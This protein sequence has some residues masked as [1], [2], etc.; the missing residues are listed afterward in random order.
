MGKKVVRILF[1]DGSIYMGDA[2]AIEVYQDSQHEHRVI[3]S[4]PSH[5]Q[6]FPLNDGKSPKVRRIFVGRI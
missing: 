2:H 3:L 6:W 4:G 1:E 5:L